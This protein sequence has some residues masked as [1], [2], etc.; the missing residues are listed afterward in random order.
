MDIMDITEI[1]YIGSIDR[2]Q[3]M[4]EIE[5]LTG[6]ADRYSEAL[7]ELL[8]EQ[9]PNAQVFVEIATD[10]RPHSRNLREGIWVNG[11]LDA[12]DADYIAEAADRLWVECCADGRVY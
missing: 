3:P 6:S 1:D 5:D 8:S 12:S 10:E 11:R 4:G 7:A 2:E 9:Y